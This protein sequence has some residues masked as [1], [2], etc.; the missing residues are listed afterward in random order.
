MLLHQPW[1]DQRQVGSHFTEGIHIHPI[2]LYLSHMCSGVC[3]QIH[4]PTSHEKVPSEGVFPCRH[5]NPVASAVPPLPHLP[6][7]Y[8]I[9]QCPTLLQVWQGSVRGL[10]LWSGALNTYTGLNPLH[11]PVSPW[12]RGQCSGPLVPSLQWQVSSPLLR[13]LPGVVNPPCGSGSSDRT[14]THRSTL[15]ARWPP[16]HIPGDPRAHFVELSQRKHI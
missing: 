8:S 5:M 15:L 13:L 10:R 3:I 16:M 9:L 6:W 14:C 11:S 4:H 1:P 2:H 7:G 12:E